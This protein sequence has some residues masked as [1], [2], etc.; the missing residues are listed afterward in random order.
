MRVH[1]VSGVADGATKLGGI[2]H[3]GILLGCTFGKA[4]ACGGEAAGVGGSRNKLLREAA[5]ADL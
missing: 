4:R 5:A 3:G 2:V 1:C